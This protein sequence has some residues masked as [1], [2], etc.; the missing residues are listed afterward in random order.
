MKAGLGA[1]AYRDR[2]IELYKFI[3]EVFSERELRSSPVSLSL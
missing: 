3:A 2:E 1:E